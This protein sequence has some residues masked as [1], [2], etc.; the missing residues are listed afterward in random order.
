MILEKNV[1]LTKKKIGSLQTR[2]RLLENTNVRLQ[3]Q[4]NPVL[5]DGHI[6]HERYNVQ[7]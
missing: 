4:I 2:I 6:L 3:N 7:F 1:T 5:K